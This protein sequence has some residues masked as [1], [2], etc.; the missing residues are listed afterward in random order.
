ML[1]INSQVTI[2][3][4][5]RFRAASS[6]VAEGMTQKPKL[7]PYPISAN[8]DLTVQAGQQHSRGA[9]R[10]ADS[11]FSLVLMFAVIIMLLNEKDRMAVLN[12][13]LNGNIYVTTRFIIY[14]NGWYV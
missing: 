14:D 12:N 3:F 1:N 10:L 2:V 6:Y 9:V 11:D 4:T 13:L 8:S 5:E 7:V